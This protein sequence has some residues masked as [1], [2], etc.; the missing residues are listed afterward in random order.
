MADRATADIGAR[1]GCADAAAQ[2]QFCDGTS[3]TITNIYNQSPW[4]NDLEIGGL[5][6]NGGQNAG[7]KAL[8]TIA[9][10]HKVYGVYVSA[11]V[12]YRDNATVGVATGSQPEGIT[13]SPP[14]TQVN[15]RCCFDYGNAETNTLDTGNGHVEAINFGT[16]CWFWP[17]SGPGPRVQADLENGLF[18]GG[19]GSW[20]PNT[21]RNSD[22]VTTVLKNNGTTTYAIKEGNA[23][24]GALTTRYDGPLPNLGGYTPVRLGGGIVLGTGGDD[25]NG[26]VG[27]FFEGVMTAGYITDAAENA[28]QANVVSVAYQAVPSFAPTAGQ[29]YAVTNVNGGKAIGAEGCA[30]GNRTLVDTSTPTGADCQKW[31]FNAAPDGTWTISNVNSGKVMDA[32]FFGQ[33]DGTSRRPLHLTGIQVE[34][35]GRPSRPAETATSWWSRAAAWSSRRPTVARPTVPA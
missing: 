12:G 3:C 9:G 10:G 1:G 26:S 33:G 23:Q 15:D 32:D 27:S 6:G 7:A 8:P 22:F 16:E 17:Y 35:N 2:D 14:A 20:V 28:V 29:T 34:N 18:A 13:W 21:G 19:N 24:A 11:G 31:A 25:S 5:G 30:T 4:Q